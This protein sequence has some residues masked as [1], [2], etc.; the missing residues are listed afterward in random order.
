MVCYLVMFRKLFKNYTCTAFCINSVFLI[1]TVADMITAGGTL[2]TDDDNRNRKTEEE[3][4]NTVTKHRPRPQESGKGDVGVSGR[5]SSAQSKAC[6]IRTHN[7]TDAPA[8]FGANAEERGPLALTQFRFSG[9]IVN[10]H[11]KPLNE[12]QHVI[13]CLPKRYGVK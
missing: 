8:G 9:D 11:A 1:L 2:K 12:C 6:L 4:K 3:V 13:K 10:T 5:E 7:R